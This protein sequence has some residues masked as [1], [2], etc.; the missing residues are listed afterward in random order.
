MKIV[1]LWIIGGVLMTT[2]GFGQ[3]Q[4]TVSECT[5]TYNVTVQ[6]RES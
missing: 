1:L 3:E 2:S 5:V 4:K 6:D